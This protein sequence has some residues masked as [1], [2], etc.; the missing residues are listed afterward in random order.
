MSPPT[1]RT[2]SPAA[3]DTLGAELRAFRNMGWSV[4]LALVAG[5]VAVLLLLP[6]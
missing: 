4:T 3:G 2:E 6:A 5:L 1:Q